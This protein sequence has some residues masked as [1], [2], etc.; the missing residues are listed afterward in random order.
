[1]DNISDELV[2]KEIAIIVNEYLKLQ[3]TEH[4]HEDDISFWSVNTNINTE[5]EPETDDGMFGTS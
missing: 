5:T 1:M 3:T 4:E 2:N